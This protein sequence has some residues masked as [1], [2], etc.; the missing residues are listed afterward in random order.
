MASIIKQVK[1][2]VEKM[3]KIGVSKREFRLNG[4]KPEIHSYKQ[5]KHTL[6]AGYNFA[7]WV[8]DEYNVKKLHQLTPE[9][10]EKYI[11]HLENRGGSKGHLRNIETALRFLE[12]GFQKFSE[13][14]GKEIITFTSEKRLIAPAK[15]TENIQD[16]SYSNFEIEQV[17]SK[18]SDNMQKA[19]TLMRELGLRSEE[20][21]KIRVEHIEKGRLFISQGEGVTKGGRHRLIEI[22][23]NLNN[24]IEKMLEG[25]EKTDRLVPIRSDSIRKMNNEAFKKAGLETDGRGCHGYRYAYAYKRV[26]ELMNSKEQKI[27]SQVLKRYGEGKNADYGVHDK[28]GYNDMKEKMDLI[29]SELGHG[30][31]RFDLAFRYMNSLKEI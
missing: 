13:E 21:S 10:Y 24:E 26:K 18:M 19:V 20:V 6:S 12:R 7:K 28:R 4:Q 25:K 31:N 30:K 27:L 15:R 5:K 1:E 17:I 11:H 29:H 2:S 23:N 3:D 14:Y 22:P 16:R 9:H 8:R